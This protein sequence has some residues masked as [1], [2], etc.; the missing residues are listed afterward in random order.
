[1]GALLQKLKNVFSLHLDDFSIGVDPLI[2]KSLKKCFLESSVAGVMGVFTGG[3]VLTGFAIA[4]G[5]NEFVF[6]LLAAIPAAVNLFQIQASRILERTGERRVL[7][8]RYAAAHRILWIVAA[9]VPFAT[10]GSWGDSRIWVFL[11]VFS[12]ASLSG[13]FSGVPFI[14]WLIDLVPEKVR[15]RFFAIRT[16]MGG[17]VGILL[18]IG[19]GKFIDF[20]RAAGFGSEIVGFSILMIIGAGFGIWSVSILSNLH[21]PQFIKPKRLEPFL[22]ALQEPFH[23]QGYRRL[24]LFRVLTDLAGGVAAPF[25]GLY[26]LTSAQL[27]FTFV[28]MLATIS[29]LA[30]LLTLPTWGKLSD[31]YG[32]KPV[33][34]I[35]IGGK[36]LF[37]VLWL[38]T[39]PETIWLFAFIH[40]LGAFDAGMGLAIPNLVYKI[41]PQERRSL[42]IA[43]DASVVGIAATVA[44]LIGGILAGLVQHLEVS[45]GSFH[46]EHLKFLFLLSF[47]SRLA[48]LPFLRRVIEPEAAR[49]VDIIRV[50]LPFRD[51]DIFEGLQQMFQILLAPVRYIRDRVSPDQEESEED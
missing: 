19:A 1:M 27:G 9:L 14:S 25:F 45:L 17:T 49:P 11:I 36:A 31:H 8:L 44:P 22:H 48:T 16:F 2:S 21:H 13:L 38:F 5:A 3:I 10:L 6:G 47:V 7:V 34:A 15:G 37:T 29:T 18:G 35:C 26:M 32:Y 41:V 42:Y 33:L 24:F 46:I 30:N 51:I 23:N 20:W 50:M 4:L 40:L 28:A 43:V 12:I 39:S